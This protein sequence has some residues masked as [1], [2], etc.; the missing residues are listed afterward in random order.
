LDTHP[1]AVLLLAFGSDDPEVTVAVSHTWP[2]A[3]FQETVIAALTE[4]P[5]ESDGHV[6][7]T[8]DP[9]T[10]QVA[11][12]DVTICGAGP[13][14]KLE[15]A[16]RERCCASLGP[17]FVAVRVNV[18]WPL[19]GCP[20]VETVCDSAR[21]AIAW[22][23]PHVCEDPLLATGSAVDV[24]IIAVLQS[25]LP[26]VADELKWTTRLN[27]AVA[28]AGNAAESVHVSVPALN[29]Q[30][31]PA[32]GDIETNVVPDG[33]TSVTVAFWASLGPMFFAVRI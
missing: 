22:T 13:V 14:K 24:L 20:L 23:V 21:S 18:A 15:L 7:V 4:P 2:T 3:D 29:E 10:E 30:L 9:A 26:S 16:V 28:P 6:Q 17:R 19:P 32:A 1:D 27:A 33:M 25:W 11:P 31:Q 8:S 12:V 5:A